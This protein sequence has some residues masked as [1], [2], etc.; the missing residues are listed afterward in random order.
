MKR[1]SAALHV[2]QA[3]RAVAGRPPM[4]AARV[5]RALRLLPG[6]LSYGWLAL[7]VAFI[8]APILVVIGASVDPG[9][10]VQL[11]AFLQFPP[12]GFSLRWY[13]EIE[14][15]LWASLW[16]SLKL[17][18]M[19]AVAAMLVGVPAALGLVRGRF[20]GK[21]VVATVFRAPLQIPFIVISIAFLQ[22][23]FALSTATGI[24]LQGTLTGLFLG[25][26]FVATPYVIGSVGTSLLRI[27]PR[28]EE[29]AQILGASRWRA[30]WRVTLPLIV[31]G[32]CG[33]L[34]YAFLISF[35]DVTL[36]VFLAGNDT[37]PFP[38]RVFTSVTTDME[39][40]IPP[41]SSLVFFGSIVL[42]YG[43]QRLLGMDA[44]L[45]SGGS[46]G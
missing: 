41:I 2:L 31:P 46:S 4:I 28:L 20:P 22:S 16:L 1:D 38:V 32:V 29:A 26:L 24:A 35:T 3:R 25:H 45:R 6:V 27:S 23:Y 39:P 5:G 11:R 13:F 7:V 19:V 44:L 40:T 18:S 34:L 8:Y 17:A 10:M 36:S 30:L 14:P 42:I 43:M 9:H 12:H 21:A 37:I 33:G 15:A